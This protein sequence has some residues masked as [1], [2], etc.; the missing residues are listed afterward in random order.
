MQSITAELSKQGSESNCDYSVI[1]TALARFADILVYKSPEVVSAIPRDAVCTAIVTVIARCTSPAIIDR[2]LVVAANFIHVCEASIPLFL[3]L[4]VLKLLSGKIDCVSDSTASDILEICVMIGR[5]NQEQIIRKFHLNQILKHVGRCRPAEQRRAMALV[6][7]ICEAGNGDRFNHCIPLLT[8]FFEGNAGLRQF[9]IGSFLGIITNAGRLPK[10]AFPVIAR[11]TS[12][13]TDLS[14]L[15]AITHAMRLLRGRRGTAIAAVRTDLDWGQLL[16]FVLGGRSAD[17]S[18]EA[19]RL[20]LEC[21]PPVGTPLCSIL[22]I[23]QT[24]A[25]NHIQ[26]AIPR[27]KGVLQ[28]IVVGGVPGSRLA[29]LALTQALVSVHEQLPPDI[30]ASLGGFLDNHEGALIVLHCALTIGNPKLLVKSGI[31]YTLQNVAIPQVRMNQWYVSGIGELA[32]RCK[33]HL[34]QPV[35]Q[36]AGLGALLDFLTTE[37]VSPL[38]FEAQ[39]LIEMATHLLRNHPRGEFLDIS[40]LAAI[41]CELLDRVSFELSKEEGTITT[42]QS[43]AEVSLYYTVLCEGATHRQVT[44]RSTS[45]FIGFEA[46]MNENNGISAREIV[47]RLPNVSRSRIESMS[48]TEKGILYRYF[49]VPGYQRY[50]FELDGKPFSPNDSPYHATCQTLTSVGGMRTCRPVVTLTPEVKPCR[51]LRCRCEP[52]PVPLSPR[53]AALLDLADAIHAFDPLLPLQAPVLE[54]R[55][56]DCIPRTIFPIIVG[57]STVLTAVFSHPFLFSLRMKADLFRIVSLDIYSAMLFTH[58]C[59][60]HGDKKLVTG[61]NFVTVTVRRDEIL[62][63]G[64][65]VIRNFG[66]GPAHMD[67]VFEGEIGFGSGITYEFLD[68]FARRL[69]RRDLGLWRDNGEG[70]FAFTNIGLFPSP[71]ADPELFYVIGLLCGKALSMT[72]ALPLPFSEQFFRFIDG[73][74]LTI[75]EIDEDFGRAIAAK[76][77]LIAAEIPFTYPGLDDLLLVENGDEVFVTDDNYEQYVRLIH[78]KTCGNGLAPVR[79]M[80]RRGLFSVIE[81]GVWNKM[82]AKEKAMLISGES[83]D[84]S[85]VDLETHISFEH[86]YDARCPQKTMLFETICEIGGDMRKNLFK[87]ITGCVPLPIGRLVSRT[88]ITVA[89][90]IDGDGQSADETLAMASTCT[91]PFR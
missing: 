72:A 88:L 63:D 27:I 22:N 74:E 71:R 14:L 48:H 4:D 36:F 50:S 24:E 62:E 75:S 7:Q 9:A 77:D 51:K 79:R 56:H 81:D 68:L 64:I 35:A 69:A 52:R 12:T 80:F 1:E 29:L 38:L 44:L 86:G 65:R 57:Y 46:W 11:L 19:L 3:R 40:P 23:Q 47:V 90:R 84:V 5:S 20:L 49:E 6:Q 76:D 21:L 45:S 43:M 17:F 55:L 61:R 28:A 91:H 10:S 16:G 13:V 89:S 34:A 39:G 25:D 73:E 67:L 8:P 78:E 42:A 37:Q 54:A 85:M 83:E 70:E 58:G 53:L 66:A 32:T 41:C 87:F 31:F 60:C 33:S 2:A 15:K 30:Y 59:L 18:G 26:R 82:T